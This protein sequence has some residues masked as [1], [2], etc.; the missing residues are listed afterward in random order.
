MALPKPCTEPSILPRSRRAVGGSRIRTYED[1]R[2]QIYS[3]LPLTARQPLR[4][5]AARRSGTRLIRCPL[6]F[7]NPGPS[8]RSRPETGACGKPGLG[9]ME[10]VGR[11]KSGRKPSGARGAGGL[12]AG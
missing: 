10:E 4:I 6:D 8:I 1:I 3:L 11:G 12:A 9:A 2:R 7:V 5:R